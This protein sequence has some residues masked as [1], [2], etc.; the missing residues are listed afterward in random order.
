MTPV[1]RIFT[2]IGATDNIMAGQSTFMVELTET[3][4][5]LQH[6]TKHS[7]VVLDELG[8]GTST[9][10]GYAIAFAVLKHLA[11]Q[12]QCRVMFSTHYHMLTD[13]FRT[14]SRIRLGHMSCLV[15]DAKGEVVFLYKLQDGVCP[16]S[17]GMH[18][19]QMAGIPKE[20]TLRAE[21]VAKRFEAE[22]PL[23]TARLLATS[24]KAKS[25]LDIVRQFATRKLPVSAVLELQKR[26]ATS[27]QLL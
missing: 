9:F 17:Y 2:R 15:D 18:V 24:S 11:E 4:N 21:E 13:E 27:H 1:D 12:C 23:S 6:A 5:I 16:K 3:C 14:S 20:I 19:A 26:L 25:V 10:D 8:R 22:A 7:L